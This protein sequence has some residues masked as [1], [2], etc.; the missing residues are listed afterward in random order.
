M[1]GPGLSS[2]V[3]FTAMLPTMLTATV[4]ATV[5]AA[6]TAALTA[7]SLPLRAYRCAYCYELTA[8]LSNL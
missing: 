8:A 7:T 5:T 4:T 3:S 6:L 1:A 2:L